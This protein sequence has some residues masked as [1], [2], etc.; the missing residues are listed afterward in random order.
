[1]TQRECEEA[2]GA[3]KSF[4]PTMRHYHRDVYDHMMAMGNN[5]YCDGYNALIKEFDSIINRLHDI[6]Y[7]LVGKR[8]MNAFGRYVV[9]LGHYSFAPGVAKAFN[10]SFASGYKTLAPRYKKYKM[11]IKAYEDFCSE[12]PRKEES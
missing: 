1:M 6:Y 10:A 3:Q 7:D 2:V 4:F 9:S 11:L 5:N 8:K 12:P